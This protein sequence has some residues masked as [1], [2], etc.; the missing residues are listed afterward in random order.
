M[1]EPPQEIPTF[2]PGR[3]FFNLEVLTEDMKSHKKKI[4]KTKA[5]IR[6]ETRDYI[7]SPSQQTGSNDKFQRIL[8][9]TCERLDVFANATADSPT[10]L[11]DQEC[12]KIKKFLASCN[13]IIK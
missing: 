9:K 4:K 12:E 10:F 11:L 1:S 5:K 6:I 13:V 8:T 2:D 3:V 7:Y